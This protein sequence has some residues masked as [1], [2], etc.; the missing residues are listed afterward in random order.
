MFWYRYMRRSALANLAPT[1]CSSLYLISPLPF[2]WWMP[3]GMG[4]ARQKV[5]HQMVAAVELQF[6]FPQMYIT[7]RAASLRRG[8]N[9]AAVAC[10][11]R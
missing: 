10:R 1:L 9:A 6:L 5:K 11:A 3:F 4:A 7:F 2:G 8:L